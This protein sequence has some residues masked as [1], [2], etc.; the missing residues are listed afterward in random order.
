M[1]ELTASK[2]SRSPCTTSA[3]SSCNRVARSSRACTK[4]RTRN[5]RSRNNPT[6][7]APV[8]PV[9]P[10]IRN[11]SVLS[12]IVYFLSISTVVG[13][14]GRSGP[15]KRVRSV[16]HRQGFSRIMLRH[17]ANT[18]VCR[19]WLRVGS[20]TQQVNSECEDQHERDIGEEL[21]PVPVDVHA[22]LPSH[23]HPVSEV[24]PHCEAEK[25]QV[26]LWIMGCAD[27]EHSP[28]DVD[29][30]Q[31]GR[32]V[33][34]LVA[35][36]DIVPDGPVQSTSVFGEQGCLNEDSHKEQGE[37]D[38]C[39]YAVDAKENFECCQLPGRFLDHLCSWLLR[40]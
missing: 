15:T 20:W 36:P 21:A 2:S 35:E 12:V 9:A 1:A 24:R 16:T 10:V 3:P 18:R 28:H 29:D 40:G 38:K 5:P 14:A 31:H 34:V 27:Q 4:A 22:S 25:R 6:V 32:D 26:G 7:G 39:E 11:R 33:V 23:E 17:C 13:V 30:H 37:D 8:L 19:R